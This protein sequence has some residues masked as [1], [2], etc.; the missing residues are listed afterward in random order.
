MSAPGARPPRIL[1]VRLGSMG[2][3]IHTLPAVAALRACLPEAVIGWAVERRWSALLATEAAIDSP[4]CPDKPLVNLVHVFDTLAWRSALLSDE[5]WR[6]VRDSLSA[7][8]SLSYDI[9]IDFQGAWKSAVIAQLSRAPR[10]IGFVEPRERP[11]TLFY[12]HP[13]PATGAH[14][15][16][17]NM[18]LIGDLCRNHISGTDL[19]AV[20]S[21]PTFPLPVDPAA[22]TAVDDQ[23]RE[24]G[25]H[26]FA[27][28]NPGAGWG[29]KCW[30]AERY[31]E[32][33]RSLALHGLRAIINFGPREEQLAREVGTL[34]NSAAR[35]EVA[36][37]LSPPLADLIALS[38]R[39]RL[40]IGGDT[41]PVHLAAAVGV[42]VVALYGPTDPARTGPVGSPAIV[43][44]SPN[45]RTTRSH[46]REPDAG[47]LEIPA[48]DVI[49]AARHLLAQTAEVHR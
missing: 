28:I 27:L 46:D 25:I 5:T 21:T 38:R 23:L 7:L 10:R 3:I 34:A 42:P 40:C 11:A 12:T 17:Q 33:A 2:D 4:R 41:G 44:R 32:V 24:L 36:T 15:V 31:A 43:L 9:A 14:I 1:V 39:A 16:Q 49:S 22:E 29:D 26:S 20:H 18:S 47:L 45:S 35:A 6:A 8:R 19:P 37:V 48:E 13:V 30:P